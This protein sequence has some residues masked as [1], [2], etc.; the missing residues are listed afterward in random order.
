MPRNVTRAPVHRLTHRLRHPLSVVFPIIFAIVSTIHYLRCHLLYPLD[1]TIIIPVVFDIHSSSLSFCLC[2]VFPSLSAFCR[3]RCRLLRRY[4]PRLS[5]L[6]I[7]FSSHSR[8]PAGKIRTWSA[9]Y[10]C[11]GPQVRILPVPVPN[12]H[13]VPGTVAATHACRVSDA[14]RIVQIVP[15]WHE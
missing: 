9:N 2:H 4:L 1:I 7:I 11:A 14:G 6:A 3:L 5:V 15:R 8:Q 13:T 10:P 12:T